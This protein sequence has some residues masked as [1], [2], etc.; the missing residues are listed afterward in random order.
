MTLQSINSRRKQLL[1]DFLRE[2]WDEGNAEAC[3][4]FLA[5]LYTIHHDP[6]D[7]CESGSPRGRRVDTGADVAGALLSVYDPA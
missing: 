1:V 7:A 6:G 5:P 2:V 3:E 4:E